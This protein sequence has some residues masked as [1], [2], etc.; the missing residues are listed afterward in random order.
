MVIEVAEG[1]KGAKMN[2]MVLQME[3]NPF[4]VMDN[5]L[6]LIS[7]GLLVEGHYRVHPD[8]LLQR[9]LL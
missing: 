8:K 7:C 3:G 1:E 2:Q 9:L 5:G 6:F 4:V